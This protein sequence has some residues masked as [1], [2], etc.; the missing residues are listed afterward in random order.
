VLRG[1]YS[2]RLD[3]VHEKRTSKDPKYTK[4]IK[5][6]VGAAKEMDPPNVIPLWAICDEWTR[7]RQASQER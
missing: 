1:F 7:E 2:F 4:R 5:R 3:K 6:V